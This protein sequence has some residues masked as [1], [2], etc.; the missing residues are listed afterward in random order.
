M[1][2][3]TARITAFRD[4]RDWQQFHGLKDEALSLMIEAGEL[5][6]HLRWHDDAALRARIAEDPEPVADELAD[7]FYWTLLIAH[8]LG[9]DLEAAFERKMLQNERKYPVAAARGNAKKYDEL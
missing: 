5:A 8:D 6:E 7:V 3:L 9:I 1:Q 2:R 4:A